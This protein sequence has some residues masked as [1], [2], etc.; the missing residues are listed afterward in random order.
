[1]KLKLITLFCITLSSMLGSCAILFPAPLTPQSGSL[2]TSV[3][4]NHN[5]LLG[6][7][8]GCV[9]AEGPKA[10]GARSGSSCS[11]TILG[12]ISSGDNSVK[13]AADNGGITQVASIDYS[14]SNVLGFWVQ[15]CIIV[16]GN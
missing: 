2:Y 12:L 7:E 6:E 5:C 13:T 9:G 4:A 15:S 14:N 16:N 11:S 3:K 10:V 8:G 1:M